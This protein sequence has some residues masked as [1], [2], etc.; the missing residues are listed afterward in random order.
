MTQLIHLLFVSPLME[1]LL[2]MEQVRDLGF[3]TFGVAKLM[4]KLDTGELVAVKFL[5]RGSL[6][7][8]A[9]PGSY[10]DA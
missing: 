6:V 2:C 8:P 10:L 3:G 7:S 5:P 1:A 9:L 4:R